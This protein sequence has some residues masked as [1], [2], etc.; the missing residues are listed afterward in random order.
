MSL[1][2]NSPCFPSPFLFLSHSSPA[3]FCSVQGLCIGSRRF[4]RER[5]PGPSGVWQAM[6]AQHFWKF[7]P[8]AYTRDLWHWTH[9]G[10]AIDKTPKWCLLQEV[11]ILELIRT[12]FLL[13]LIQIRILP[14][15]SSE[16][17]LLSSNFP[18]FTLFHHYS[19]TRNGTISCRPSPSLRGS[20][21]HGA[22]EPLRR[23]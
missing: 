22:G 11:Y 5:V 19:T 9:I 15:S 17:I 7:S 13:V 10:L 3:E 18:S 23:H 6:C 16:T 8:Q 21:W 12:L 4:S 20:R 2:G 14:A 1:C